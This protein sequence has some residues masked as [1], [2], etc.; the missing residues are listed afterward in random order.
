MIKVSVLYPNEESD[1]FDM[2]Y[3]CDK[4]IPMVRQLLGSSCRDAAI[5]RGLAGGTPGSAPTYTV[6]GHLFFDKVEDFTSSLTPHADV[7]NSDI[8]NFTVSTPIIQISEVIL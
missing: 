1:T 5:E 4:H 8:A 7:I 3:Y 2:K 6:M